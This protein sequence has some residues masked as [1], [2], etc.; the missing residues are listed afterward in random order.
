MRTI[1]RATRVGGIESETP[2]YLVTID[3]GT[4]YAISEKWCVNVG[5]KQGYRGLHGMP[6]EH[7]ETIH[8]YLYDEIA[9]DMATDRPLWIAAMGDEPSP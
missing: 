6:P 8:D 1:V 7:A 3:D 9:P 2:D 4:Q 5:T